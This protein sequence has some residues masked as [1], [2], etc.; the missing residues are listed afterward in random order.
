MKP[1]RMMPFAVAPH[2]RMAMYHHIMLFAPLHD[3]VYRRA[4]PVRLHHRIG[5]HAPPVFGVHRS[6]GIAWR[7]GLALEA[8][9]VKWNCGPVEKSSEQFAV[10]CIVRLL[11]S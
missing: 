3:L 4:A 6:Y 2:E 1:F 8:F 11:A 7:A 5:S 10:S 9:P